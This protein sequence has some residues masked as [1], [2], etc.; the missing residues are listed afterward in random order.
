MTRQEVETSHA[1]IQEIDMIREVLE[2]AEV[3][4]A[5]GDVYNLE[6]VRVNGSLE[7]VIRDALSERRKQ[8][9]EELK[10]M[11]VTV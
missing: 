6:P 7:N 2:H 10:A 5:M 3:G 9:K 8:I 4:V 1:L 11:G